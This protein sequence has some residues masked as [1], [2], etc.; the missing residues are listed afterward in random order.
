M[1]ERW[2]WSKDS[3]ISFKQPISAGI[4]AREEYK[5]PNHAELV[6]RDWTTWVRVLECLAREKPSLVDFCWKFS[7]A[8]LFSG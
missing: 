8:P 6:E 4:P 3:N 2:I 5:E 1:T 7:D